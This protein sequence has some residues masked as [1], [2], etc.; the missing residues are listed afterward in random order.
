M[1]LVRAFETAFADAERKG[2]SYIYV[3]IDL[4]STVIKPNYSSGD[5]PKEFYDGAL[6]ALK[7][8]TN[9]DDMKI[10]MYT[11]SHPQEIK[12]Y[13]ELFEEHDIT[14]DYINENPEVTTT[15]QGYGNYDMK[16]Y[17]NVLFEDK[18]SFNAET[19]WEPIVYYLRDRNSPSGNNERNKKLFK[20]MYA[21]EGGASLKVVL[22]NL[23]ADGLKR[24]DYKIYY[25][26]GRDDGG[27]KIKK[28]DIVL[29]VSPNKDP[30]LMVVLNVSKDN[31]CELYRYNEMGVEEKIVI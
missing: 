1:N 25:G 18:A 14:F 2:W 3:F 8:M 10:I 31:M 23:V 15:P 20:E 13:V 11:C 9:T 24:R 16:P 12:K 6:E 29:Y 27:T 19:D 22:T 21:K 17:F 7:L 26:G 28:Y 5:I 4:H 30:H